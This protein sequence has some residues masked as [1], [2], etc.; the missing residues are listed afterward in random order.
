MTTTGQFNA[1]SYFVDRHANEGRERHVA[2]EYETER[3]TYGQ[4]LAKVNQLG[5]ALRHSLEVRMEER[6]FLL[7]LDAPEFAY[8]FF[9]SIKIGAVPVPVNTLLKPHDYEYLLNDSRARVAIVSEPLLH[10]ITQIPRERLPF[11]RHIVVCGSPHRDAISFTGLTS[12]ESG[13]LSPATTCGDDVA[14][15]LY[16]SGSTGPPKG[17]VHLQH[18]MVV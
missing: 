16:S 15:W 12:R 18:D 11:L 5:N 8:S 6:V 2:I 14:F 13:D 4:L 3:I 7:L 17:C 9:G 1:A 10:T